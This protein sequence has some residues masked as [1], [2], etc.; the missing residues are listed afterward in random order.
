LVNYKRTRTHNFTTKSASC[1]FKIIQKEKIFS[2]VNSKMAII[3]TRRPSPLQ[4]ASSVACPANAN[5]PPGQ[6]QKKLKRI[7]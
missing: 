7:S 3:Y 5:Q 2:L 4:L 1:P 6:F